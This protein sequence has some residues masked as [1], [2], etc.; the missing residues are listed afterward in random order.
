MIANVAR[1]PPIP[2]PPPPAS[3]CLVA[4][5]VKRIHLLLRRFRRPKLLLAEQTFAAMGFDVGYG[6]TLSRRY[7]RAVYKDG[8]LKGLRAQGA[9]HGVV[10]SERIAVLTSYREDTELSRPEVLRAIIREPVDGRVL[11]AESVAARIRKGSGMVVLDIDLHPDEDSR[12]TTAARDYIEFQIGRAIRRI[13]EELS[14]GDPECLF[15]VEQ[16]T[17]SP[18]AH[19]YA[20]VAFEPSQKSADELA[21][22]IAKETDLSID[23]FTGAGGGLIALPFAARYSSAGLFVDALGETIRDDALAIATGHA[24]PPLNDRPR[25]YVV[26]CVR[27]ADD[28]LAIFAAMRAHPAPATGALRSVEADAPLVPIL[29][30]HLSG[31]RSFTDPSMPRAEDEFGAGERQQRTFAL[32]FDVL[33][34]GGSSEDFETR[35]LAADRGSKDLIR[36]K[37]R[38]VLDEKLRKA[39]AW[40]QAHYKNSTSTASSIVC[41]TERVIYDV[42]YRRELQDDEDRLFDVIFDAFTPRLPPLSESA[43]ED[44][45]MIAR[46]IP[47]LRDLLPG[48]REAPA[49]L[50]LPGASRVPQRGGRGPP[51]PRTPRAAPEARPRLARGIS[52]CRRPARARGA[53]VGSS[54]AP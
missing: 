25:D 11:V 34:Q 30:S 8:K 7:D 13:T 32:A 17:F 41:T 43:R 51:W 14:G 47:R 42:D 12:F 26:P 16:K 44:T 5:Q 1:R 24:L 4:E 31:G 22:R 39:F 38:G 28:V 29:R 40:A 37:H 27:D 35:M 2:Q 46:E 33:R 10:P 45:R 3:S 54:Q 19:V 50:Q 15:Y 6:S 49:R 20:V 53:P 23:A 18:G 52:A 9:W 36:W 21:Q 48:R